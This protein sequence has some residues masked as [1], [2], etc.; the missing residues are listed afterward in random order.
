[1]NTPS[2]ATDARD[3]GVQLSD[4]VRGRRC[5][6]VGAGGF[7]GTSL[8]RALDAA[9][10]E[11]T[12][13]GRSPRFPGAIEGVRF[14]ETDAADHATLVEALSGVDSVFL[15][16]GVASPSASH[17]DIPGDAQEHLAGGVRTVDACL[18]AGVRR[19]VFVSSGGTVYGPNAPVPSRESAPTEPIS[20][21]GV[22]KLALEKYV[23]LYRTQGL[24]AVV[25]RVSNPFGAYQL[26]R[27][28]QGLIASVLERAIRREPVTVFGDGSAIRDYVHVADVV[29]AMIR[30]AAAGSPPPVMNIGAGVGRSIADVLAAIESELDLRLVIEREPARSVDV[31]ASVLDV[32]LASR[33]LGWSP[34][35]SFGDGLRDAYA[36]MVAEG[37]G[38][39]PTVQG[40]VHAAEPA[41]R[42]EG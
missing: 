8:L 24:D 40:T 33:A 11:A 25:L 26:P 31:P 21:Y 23:G 16:T 1:M 6:V 7:L 17:A 15:L 5:A 2:A 37:L 22:A 42:R 9:G 10:A 13:I 34:R 27:R 20:A 39:P 29:D 41:A 14:V 12:G 36:W 3:R 4:L 35:V 30:A 32:S 38:E 18:R 19:V 28:G